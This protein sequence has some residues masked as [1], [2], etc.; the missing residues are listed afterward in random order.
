MLDSEVSPEL[1]V[2]QRDWLRAEMSQ[3]SSSA[4]GDWNIVMFHR[5]PFTSGPHEPNLDMRPE[6]GWDYDAWGADLV[7][8][9]HQHVYEELEVDGLPYLVAGVGAS[10]LVR[11]CPTELVTESAGCVEG[12]GAILVTATDGSLTLDYRKPD[13][14]AGTSLRTLQLSR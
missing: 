8:T 2:Q 12:Y 1:L 13:G 3:A 10:G 7:V 5:P 4:P 11:P 9:G 6:A 14:A